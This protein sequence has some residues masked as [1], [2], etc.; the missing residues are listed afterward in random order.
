VANALQGSGRDLPVRVERL[1]FPYEYRHE[2]PFPAQEALRAPV[3]QSFRRVFD[4][5]AEFL[6]G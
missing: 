4:L 3:D 6:R 1:D 5:V 2:D